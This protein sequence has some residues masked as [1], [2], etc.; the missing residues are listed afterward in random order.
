MENRIK[1]RGKRDGEIHENRMMGNGT[2]FRCEILI[3]SGGSHSGRGHTARM[4]AR[5]PFFSQWNEKKVGIGLIVHVV[6]VQFFRSS[7]DWNA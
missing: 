6:K 7:K 4:H 1:E 3:F 5:Q 2:Q